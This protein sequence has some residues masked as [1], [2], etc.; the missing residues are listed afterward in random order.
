M[1]VI[2][3]N[4]FIH[5]PFQILSFKISNPLRYVNTGVIIAAA[6]AASR[7]VMDR[8]AEMR[9]I[10]P[11]PFRV[12]QPTTL[13]TLTATNSA[14]HEQSALNLLLGAVRFVDAGGVWKS[15]SFI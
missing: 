14:F 5:N 11:F 13:D 15:K 10:P 3:N 6:N 1:T 4:S 2:D 8:I 12:S 7:I 9:Y